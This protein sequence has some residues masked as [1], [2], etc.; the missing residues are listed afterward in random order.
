MAQTSLV[1]RGPWEGQHKSDGM[2]FRVVWMGA[3]ESHGG[4]AGGHAG[5]TGLPPPGARSGH[6]SHSLL[7]GTINFPD[8]GEGQMPDLNRVSSELWCF[9][10]IFGCSAHTAIGW[11]RIA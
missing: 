10:S 8:N 2:P 7:M 6:V 3:D 4:D 1:V 9:V 5:D 11:K